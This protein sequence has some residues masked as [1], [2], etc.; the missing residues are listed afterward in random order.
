MRTHLAEHGHELRGT[1]RPEVPFE[2]PLG[3]ARIRGRID[4]MLRANG[5]DR[6]VE[7]IDFK[8]Y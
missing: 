2:V 3:H 7:L 5:G 8:T 4:H 1:T 6:R